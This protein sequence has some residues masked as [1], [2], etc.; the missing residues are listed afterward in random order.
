M[1]PTENHHFDGERHYKLRAECLD[2][3]LLFIHRIPTNM[4][5]MK[6]LQVGQLPDVEFEFKTTLTLDEILAI[7]SKQVDSHVMM[8]TL[9]PFDEYTGERYFIPNNHKS[10][11]QK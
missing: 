3:V 2:D 8:E 9:R 6:I 10:R 1:I 7:L 5:E 4:S 11:R